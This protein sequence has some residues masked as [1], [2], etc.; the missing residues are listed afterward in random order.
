M[1]CHTKFRWTSASC[2]HVGLV[3]GR[4]EDACLDQPER[5]L[6]A[7]ADG[8]GGHALG[9]VA[10]RMVVENLND[11]PEP[12]SLEQFLADTRDRLQTTN[13][14]LRAAAATR[15]VPIIGSTVVA[16]LACDHACGYLWAGDS[17][18]YLYR[19]GRLK[20]LTR[21]HSQ[22][23]KFR[24][25]NKDNAEA[26]EAVHAP[27]RNMITRAVGAAD[28][29]ETDE[30]MME[31]H[32]G[33]IFLLCS[34]GLSNAV[35]EQEMC[36]ELVAGNCQQAVESLVELALKRGGRDNISVVVVRADDLY[37]SDKTVLNPAL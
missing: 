35:S 22:L 14:Q 18:I 15:G 32:D 36:S 24:S 12:N 16:L 27:P 33:D 29:L 9:D 31:V 19:N 8:M 5:K 6:W 1:T 28:T 23:E 26:A 25:Q 17:R 30:A 10:S 11:I 13:R 21:D 20:Q 3:R 34:D 7:V 37:S 2:S 4:N